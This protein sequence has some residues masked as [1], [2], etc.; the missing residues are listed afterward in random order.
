MAEGAPWA[1]TTGL[2]LAVWAGSV[3]IIAPTATAVQPPSTC[4]VQTTQVEGTDFS[5]L[6]GVPPEHEGIA[7]SMFVGTANNDC[8]RV[9]SEGV[10]H[11]PDGVVEWGWVLGYHPNGGNV[12]AGPGYCNNRYYT[13][14]ELF[15]VWVPVGGGYHCKDVAAAT[16]GTHILDTY[17]TSTT[18]W[19][20]TYDGPDR[21]DLTVN[22]YYGT[23]VTNG[24]RHNPSDS[25]AADFQN[26]KK[27]TTDDTSWQPFE[28]SGCYLDDDSSYDW[29]FYSNT[30]THVYLHAGAG[31]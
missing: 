11:G 2:T 23:A 14:P 30:H 12:Y 27:R 4:V 6:V 22:F 19:A 16:P 13:T 5:G 28:F 10:L 1:L 21:A 20:N 29:Y 9:S 7:S 25:A 31:C 15:I 26:L 17:S 3:L 18:V 8:I 24:E